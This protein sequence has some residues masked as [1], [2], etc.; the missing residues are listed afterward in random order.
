MLQFSPSSLALADL[1]LP[2]DNLP[3]CAVARAQVRLGEA[4]PLQTGTGFQS[5]FISGPGN[6]LSM[7]ISLG[8][9]YAFE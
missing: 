2:S 3:S 6:K 4:A 9:K 5:I 1:F 7:A 8:F